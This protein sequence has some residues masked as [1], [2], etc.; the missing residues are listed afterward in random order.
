SSPAVETITS[1]SNFITSSNNFNITKKLFNPNK[2]YYGS[3][4]F[5]GVFVIAF[6]EFEAV[7]AQVVETRSSCVRRSVSSHIAITSTALRS[8]LIPARAIMVQGSYAG[9]VEERQASSRMMDSLVCNVVCLWGCLSLRLMNLKPSRQRSWKLGAVVYDVP[10]TKEAVLL[11][12]EC[13]HIRALEASSQ[14]VCHNGR[15]VTGN[16]SSFAQAIEGIQAEQDQT[17]Q[18]C[19]TTGRQWEKTVS[20][21]VTHVHLG[22]A[23]SG[24]CANRVMHEYTLNEEELR[25]CNH[26]ENYYNVCKF[27]KKS[28]AGPK[29]GEQYGAPFVEEE[30]AEDDEYVNV[31]ALLMKNANMNKGVGPVSAPAYHFTSAQKVVSEPKNMVQTRSEVDLLDDEFK[32]QKYGHK[33][34]KGNTNPSEKKSR[35]VF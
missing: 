14:K 23:P 12:L 25:R 24:Q 33:V 34:V 16:G 28:G 18:L 22:C 11:I 10:K 20:L 17:R 32:W 26:V 15:V 27:F 3:S 4:L 1:S 31:D 2:S 30:W 21:L 6:N 7:K 29:N 5:M 35:C 8:S 9:A 13:S 19:M